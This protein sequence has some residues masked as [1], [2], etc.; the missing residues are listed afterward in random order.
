MRRDLYA[1]RV[2]VACLALPSLSLAAVPFNEDFNADHTASWTV[3]DS[4]LSDVTA[5]FFYDYSAIG[6]PAAPGGTG[7][8]GL[9]L[10]AN[11]SGG[12]FS[13]FSVSPN[14]Q[15]FSGDYR[16][17]FDMWQNY[18]GPL[19][20]GGNGTTQ[21]TLYGIGTAGNVPI[22]AGSSPK[23]SVAF[24]T[25]LDGGSAADY[26]AY[27][28]AAPT[29]YADGD[30]VYA[31]PSRNNSHAYYAVFT[32]QSA[33]AAQVGL[34]P[35]QTGTTDLGETAFLWR[36]VAIDVSGGLARWSI[37]GV[38]L[39]TVDLSTVTLGGGNIFFGHGDTN[40]TS[41]NDPNDSLL[42]VTLIDNINVVPEP[43]GLGLAGLA[44]AALAVRRRR[45]G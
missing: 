16:V 6:V 7:T 19:G 24:G 14:G 17:E 18:V 2:L 1:R 28:S 5:D 32:G 33:P 4:G 38:P 35:G 12:V 36:R 41:S 25:T 34:F 45:R 30:P 13:G 44:A 43:V 9:K 20:P 8:R 31:A 15:S 23:E 26:R 37:D 3:N 27:S 22:W 29:S 11:N 10:T 40:A 21:L 39:A 42:N